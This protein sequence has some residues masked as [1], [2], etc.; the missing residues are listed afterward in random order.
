MESCD[1]N[2]RNCCKN[3][4]IDCHLIVFRCVHMQLKNFICSHCGK[5]YNRSSHYH[6]HVR[7]AH[8]NLDS[9]E[10]YPCKTCGKVFKDLYR[11][12]TESYLYTCMV[13]LQQAYQ[14]L[15]LWFSLCFLSTRSWL[16]L[17]TFIS[18]VL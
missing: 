2:L 12:R 15:R 7:E 13:S 17:S 3:Y 11:V 6:R 5:G 4:F 8:S 9:V 10:Q 14:T 16:F 18:I 1:F